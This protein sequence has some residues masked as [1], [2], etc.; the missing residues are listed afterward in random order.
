MKIQNYCIDFSQM[1]KVVLFGTHPNQFNGYSKVVYEISKVMQHRD[2]IEFMVYGF[3]QFYK[4]ESHRK[5]IPYDKVVIYDAFG[6]EEPKKDGFGFTE[7]ESFIK[8]HKPDVCI[9]YND[10]GVTSQCLLKIRASGVK[11][12]IIAYI[13]QVY[14]NQRKEFIKLVNETA[15][16]AVAF[17][18]YWEDILKEQGI[19]LPTS[20]LQHGFNP[21]TYYPIPHSI[22]RKFYGISPDDFVILN[23]N[24][25]QPR[26]RWDTCLK[27]FAEVVSRLPEKPIKMVIATAMQGA[28]NLL[29]IY[30]RELKK[31]NISLE[32][33]MKHLIILDNPQRITDEETNIL[34]NVADIGINT[35]EGEGFG[36][37]NFEQAALGIPQVVPHL[38]GFLDFFNDDNAFLVQPTLAYYVDNSRDIVSG[39]ALMSDYMD[40]VE[41][42]I[43]YYEN[44]ELRKVHG[45]NA[46]NNILKN[47][48]WQSITNKLIDIIYQVVPDKKPTEKSL[49]DDIDEIDITNLNV[50]QVEQSDVQD[51]KSKLEELKKLKDRIDEILNTIKA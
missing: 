46:R 49:C 39:E 38:G 31:R 13:D 18:P 33:G 50:P 48:S 28:W 29:E 9:I 24:R 8:E 51:L 17:T 2:D 1:V 15:D 34:Y 23:L 21:D 12:K 40:F 11:T 35:C 42:T 14:L 47:Y 41:G 16:F 20:Y 22:A 44:R 37:C 6:N 19:L 26:K 3:Q 4:N 43:Q 27:A 45:Q 10:L 25:N 32:E 5:D 30:E 36:L 7:I